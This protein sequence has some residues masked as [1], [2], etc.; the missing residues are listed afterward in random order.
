MCS[1]RMLFCGLVYLHSSENNHRVDF[2]L[3]DIIDVEKECFPSCI[4][5]RCTVF[6]L[7]GVHEYGILERTRAGRWRLFL[8]IAQRST[9]IDIGTSLED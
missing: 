7:R 1:G 9:E 6:F 5:W 3:G 8:F 2:F 4:V